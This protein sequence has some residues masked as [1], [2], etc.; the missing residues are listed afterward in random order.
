M[1]RTLSAY[2]FYDEDDDFVDDR[3]S[4][5]QGLMTTENGSAALRERAASQPPGDAHP[6]ISSPSTQHLLP[7]SLG[8]PWSSSRSMLSAARGQ[9]QQQQQP[10]LRSASYT[11]QSQSNFG[12]AMRDRTFPST[13]EV[14]ESE[15]FADTF[16]ERYLPAAITNAN[17]GRPPITHDP[18][19]SRSQSLATGRQAPIGS[20]P[21]I[22]TTSAQ[23]SWNESYL[24][25]SS[26]GLKPPGASRHPTLGINIAVGRPDVS[27]MSPLTRD[28][29]QI[30]LDDGPF[31]ELW[32]G[33][34]PPR[35]EVGGGGGNGTTSRRHSVSVAP[36]RT[37]T[38]GF[39]APTAAE[40]AEE[41]KN[42]STATAKFGIV[43]TGNG[44]RASGGLMLSDDDLASDLGKLNLSPSES[45]S[46]Q[47]PPSQP[48]SLP[49]YA[50]L[51]RSPP[52]RDILS[53]YQPINLTIP[54][55][56]AT[57]SRQSIGT[58]SDNGYDLNTHSP[59]ISSSVFEQH[60]AEARAIQQQ[61]QA[62]LRYQFLREQQQ[63]QQQH[64]QQQQARPRAPSYSAVS[65]GL[66]SPIS[67]SGSRI[68][69]PQQPP[70]YPQTRKF[71]D[72]HQ[73]QPPTPSTPLHPHTPTN[74]SELGKGLPLHAVPHTW[75]LFIV[76]FKAGRTDLFYLPPSGTHGGSEWDSISPDRDIRV[77]DL[78]IVEADRG[79]D[80]G[81]VVNDRITL[82][83]VEAFQRMQA[84]KAAA[85]GIGSQGEP[86]SP[87]GLMGGPGGDSGGPS[88]K[89]EINPKMIYG[90]AGPQDV[91]L[92][93]AKM[94]D[95]MKALQ[96]C[97]TKVRAKKLPMEVIDAEYQW[98]VVLLR[99]F[100]LRK[101]SNWCS[102]FFLF[103]PVRDRRKLTFYF[104]AEK[105]IDFRELV[106]ELFRYLLRVL[107]FHPPI[108][109]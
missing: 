64:Q 36:R 72:A 58:P 87:G 1:N 101:A 29:G 52:S 18:S 75:P 106:R 107:H 47:Q 71:S 21:Y 88:Q 38:I 105:R 42:R 51:S 96:L 63:Q 84:E 94:Q 50:P 68:V 16:D 109:N 7:S 12:S 99:N 13:Y 17:R 66:H 34:N 3:R 81:K 39:N 74:L 78:V 86:T 79:K 28:V 102:F 25:N 55:G 14:D 30:L 85:A 65:G 98:C 103:H 23:Q 5:F 97:Q 27:N 48:A 90:K 76:E 49:I 100:L 46:H 56:N 33:M 93:A 62:E 95:E 35:D 92:Y 57:F 108:F 4:R 11:S 53:T 32:A 89:K 59:S 8:G 60:L 67:P 19:R 91:Q 69:N 83:E 2:E 82:E 31:R 61:Q 6:S 24:T 44:K 9:Q 22:S 45:K 73:Q 26:S 41:Q 80:L 70:Y 40:Q 104:I 15:D 37:N 10:P 20:M 54:S 43:S 77:G